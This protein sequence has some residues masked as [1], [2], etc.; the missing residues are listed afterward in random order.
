MD[1]IDFSKVKLK[2]EQRALE[3]HELQQLHTIATGRPHLAGCLN[4]FCPECKKPMH[5]VCIGTWECDYCKKE[6]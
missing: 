3:L 6:G 2:I 5:H 1:N 4:P